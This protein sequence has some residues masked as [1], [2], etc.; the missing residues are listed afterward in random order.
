MHQ[1]SETSIELRYLYKKGNS[2]IVCKT[3]F[4]NFKMID[5][6]SVFLIDTYPSGKVID[7][8]PND[9]LS[10]EHSHQKMGKFTVYFKDGRKPV[11]LDEPLTKYEY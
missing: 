9:I 11:L 8:N 2:F 10:I 6:N 7:L 3:W 4:N 1:L 5:V